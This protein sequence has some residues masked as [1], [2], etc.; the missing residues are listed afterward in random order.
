MRATSF[1]DP[2]SY[3]SYRDLLWRMLR[4]TSEP[5]VSTALR[6]EAV[7]NWIGW[8]IARDSTYLA[9]VKCHC[10]RVYRDRTGRRMTGAGNGLVPH[11]IDPSYRKDWAG[12]A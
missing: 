2:E 8:C 9:A 4:M 1:R 5:R 10:N 11:E 6:L 12:S 7:G 3:V